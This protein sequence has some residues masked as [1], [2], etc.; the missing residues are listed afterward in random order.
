MHAEAG[1][2]GG[3]EEERN[4]PAG[5]VRVR[6]QGREEDEKQTVQEEK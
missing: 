2:G 5:S 4:T 1:G 3:E 6:K